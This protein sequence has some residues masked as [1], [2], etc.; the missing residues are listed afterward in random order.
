MRM[1]K[2]DEINY[3]FPA[4]CGLEKSDRLTAVADN[5]DEISFFF[6][7]KTR[8]GLSNFWFVVDDQNMCGGNRRFGDD[9]S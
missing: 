8:Q 5:V 4:N 6:E 3:L 9:L 2:Q 7:Q 1:S